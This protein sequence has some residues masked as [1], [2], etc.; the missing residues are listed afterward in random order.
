MTGDGRN[1]V[2]VSYGGNKPNAFVA[3]LAY[4]AI[5]HELEPPVAYSSYDLPR[6]VDVADFDLDGLA[7]LVTLHDAW[8]AAGVYRQQAAG[9]LSPEELYSLPYGDY[10]PHG[11]A[12]G[13]VNGDGSPDVVLA[14]DNHGLVLL[15]NTTAPTGVPHTPALTAA[16]AGPGSVALTWTPPGSQGGSPSGYKV[17]R[18]TASGAETLLTTLG[19]ATSTSTRRQSPARTTTASAPSTRSAKARF[20]TS[21]LRLQRVP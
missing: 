5:T 6:P 16:I 9:A 15:R 11:L 20:R 19:S 14:D 3:V 8:L 13:D 10:E 1:D 17:Y 7:D 12:V 18:G 2:V 4:N 21:A